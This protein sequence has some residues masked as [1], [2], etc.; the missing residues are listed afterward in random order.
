[1]TNAGL[2]SPIVILATTSA[3][4]VDGTASHGQS[5]IR[6]TNFN[7]GE[8]AEACPPATTEVVARAACLEARG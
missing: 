5:A 1:M 4:H 7:R 3:R 6:L 8:R 2:P